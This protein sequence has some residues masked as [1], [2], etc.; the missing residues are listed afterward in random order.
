MKTIIFVANVSRDLY[1]FRLG[2][3]RALKKEGFDIIC[4]APKDDYS[5]KFE[6]E[7]F[8]FIQ[9]KFLDRKEKSL[10]KNL[11][12]IQELYKI[13]KRFKPDL[14]I[15]YTIKP[16]I[17]GNIASKIAK[18][19]SISVITGLGS[20]FVKENIIQ[21]LIK[22]LYRFSL[23]FS[24]KVFFL[25]RDDREFFIKNK[26]INPSKVVLINGEGINTNYFSP[27]CTDKFH[28]KDPNKNIFLLISRLL[29][30]KG[31]GEFV[32]SA[33]K[34]KSIYS[35][36]EFWIL[37]PVDTANP[38]AI[39]YD[40]VKKWEEEG[41]IRYLGVTEDV[42]PFITQSTAVVLPSYRE[43]VPRSLLEAISMGKPIITTD[44]PGCREV[45]D[46]RKNGFLVPVRDSEALAVA[47]IKLLELTEEERDKMG[48][49]G[50]EKALK[51]FDERVI[52]DRYREI[53]DE[54][55]GG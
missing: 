25:N 50:R 22:I 5:Q 16:I 40:T 33:K 8:I 10:L 37:G 29:W 51:E 18:I 11:L 20:F 42:R 21:R 27:D 53:I 47:M 26:I 28:K 9:S 44:A 55:L 14:V 30:D 1:N 34:V 38:T 3:M 7:G 52:I 31:I 17:F 32:E 23:R 12:I 41:L 49:Y 45:I 2:L 35:N 24:E 6:E 54:I 48:M 13:Y 39:P 46:D 4:I 36:T 43:G 15:L 19:K